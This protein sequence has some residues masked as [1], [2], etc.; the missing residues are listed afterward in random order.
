V[1]GQIPQV[2]FPLGGMTGIGARRKEGK[3]EQIHLGG[4]QL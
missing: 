1:E 3:T 2:D 4:L